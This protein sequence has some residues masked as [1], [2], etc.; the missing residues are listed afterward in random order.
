MS[1]K[2]IF[3]RIQRTRTTSG[4]DS[5]ECPFNPAK[6]GKPEESC[7]RGACKFFDDCPSGRNALKPG[8]EPKP[9]PIKDSRTGRVADF[10]RPPHI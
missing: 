6:R 9:G 10:D 3:E 4:R 2:E 8:E 1:L 5:K 7:R